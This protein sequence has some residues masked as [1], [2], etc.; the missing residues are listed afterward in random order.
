M[1]R[2][3]GSLYPTAVTAPLERHIQT[4]PIIRSTSTST[5]TNNI[6]A[7]ILPTPS[8]TV[9]VRSLYMSAPV[10]PTRAPLHGIGPPSHSSGSRFMEYWRFTLP[11]LRRDA[12]HLGWKKIISDFI[13]MKEIKWGWLQGVDEFGIRYYM[14]PLA[15]AGRTRW[16]VF[17][18][19]KHA[20]ARQVSESLGWYGWLHYQWDQ[21]PKE[22]N[23]QPYEWQQPPS[24]RDTYMWDEKGL[25][26]EWMPHFE[27]HRQLGL[28]ESKVDAN[29][30]RSDPEK[31][32]ASEKL[33]FDQHIKNSH[34][35]ADDDVND[36]A[37]DKE[38]YEVDHQ[39]WKHYQPWTKEP[40]PP[41]R[42]QPTEA[43]R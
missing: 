12:R 41:E 35:Y 29:A 28:T 27:Y 24:D 18:D 6:N 7:T 9:A 8:S 26:P 43:R 31:G 21:T 23:L 20:D 14:N 37:N 40:P 32:A 34:P 15:Q 36:Y 39:Q 19:R 30:M 22:L 11:I 10:P 42:G 25:K 3:I 38:F 5:S 1:L 13:Q 16:C 4:N 17:P 2:R 33:K